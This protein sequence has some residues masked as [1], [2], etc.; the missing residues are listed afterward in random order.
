MSTE[1]RFDNLREFEAKEDVAEAVAVAIADL[2]TD[3]EGKEQ[4]NIALS[5]GS[6]PDV[7]FQVWAAQ[8]PDKMP[9]E[10]LHF[11]WVDERCVPPLNTD[12]NYG[13]VKKILFDNINIPAANI[14]RIKGELSPEE[15]LLA[16]T[17]E[18]DQYLPI[19]NGL[20]K[21]DV[22]LLG[23]GDDGHTAS[24]FPD[25]LSLLSSLENCSV[26]T[27]P[28]SSQKRITLTGKVIE[29]A[30][31]IAFLVTGEGKANVMAEIMNETGDYREYPAYHIHKNAS[32][33]LWY[34]DQG[35]ASLIK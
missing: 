30:A 9:W 28:Q 26:A 5:G 35:A 34:V 1:L 4:I 15:S 14:H 20:P 7:L 21:F 2:L 25:N 31:N 12:S 23:M 27:H 18:L 33:C 10:R 16:Y 17:D 22:L 19:S 32:H 3:Y 11:Y 29:N 24:I 6:T 8:Y 13:R